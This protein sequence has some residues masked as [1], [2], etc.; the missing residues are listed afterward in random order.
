MMT[1]K[2]TVSGIVQTIKQNTDLTSHD[3][4]S[5]PTAFSRSILVE[6]AAAL[7]TNWGGAKSCTPQLFLKLAP[8][9]TPARIETAD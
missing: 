4:I 3:F 6:S 1:L 9:A 8:Q 7:D 5:F 2:T